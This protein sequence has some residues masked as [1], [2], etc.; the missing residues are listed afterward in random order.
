MLNFKNVF[1]QYTSK[2]REEK[3]LAE[4]SIEHNEEIN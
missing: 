2:K 1:Q 3:A 4:I